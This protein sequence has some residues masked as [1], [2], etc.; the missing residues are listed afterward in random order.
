MQLEITSPAS[1]VMQ[2]TCTT[3]RERS[4][5]VS[6]VESAVTFAIRAHLAAL[7]LLIIGAKIPLYDTSDILPH[8]IEANLSWTNV[9]VF[10]AAALYLLFRRG[11][12]EESLLVMQGVGIQT[13]SSS[14]FFLRS[15]SRFFPSAVVKD[16]IINEALIGFTVRHYLALIVADEPTL[17]GVFPRLLPPTCMIRQVWKGAR[18]CLYNK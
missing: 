6:V 3:R 17:V 13:T 1:N 14:P 18:G 2:F 4:L 10:C 7:I 16:I 5:F 12:V 15:S 8:I 9:A 11:Y